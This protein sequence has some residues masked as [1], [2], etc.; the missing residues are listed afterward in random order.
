MIEQLIEAVNKP[1]T[2]MH[3]II[4]VVGCGV[5]YVTNVIVRIFW[6]VWKEIREEKRPKPTFEEMNYSCPT[7]E[8][9]D[10]SHMVY[11]PKHPHFQA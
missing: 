7:C 11:C 6:N 8:S 3:I 9:N 10:G 1:I 5:W 4:W 2:S